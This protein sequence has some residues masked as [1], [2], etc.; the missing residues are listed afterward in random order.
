MPV[1]PLVK[2]L[3]ERLFGRPEAGI[4]S[5][6]YVIASGRRVVITNGQYWGEHGVSNFWYGRYLSPDGAPMTEEWHGYGHQLTSIPPP[7][8]VQY[9]HKFEDREYWRINA[10]GTRTPISAPEDGLPLFRA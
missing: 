4:G 6:L 3:V 9:Y 7:Y 8:C 5:E 10:G 2:G 1:N